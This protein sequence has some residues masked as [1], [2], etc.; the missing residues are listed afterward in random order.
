MEICEWVCWQVCR[1][2]LLTQ[3]QNGTRSF[4]RG[5]LDGAELG[6]GVSIIMTILEIAWIE[7]TDPSFLF[8]LIDL[9][10]CLD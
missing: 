1:H 2:S 9:H 8:A 3:Y 5:A 4:G 7:V 10:I 6:V